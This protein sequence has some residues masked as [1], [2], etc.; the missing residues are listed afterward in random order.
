MESDEGKDVFDVKWQVLLEVFAATVTT[1]LRRQYPF[2]FFY[3]HKTVGKLP[4][5]A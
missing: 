5:V 2:F 4:R 1:E 3:L